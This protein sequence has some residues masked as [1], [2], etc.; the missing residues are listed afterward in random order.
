MNNDNIVL[1][2]MTN[3]PAFEF[4]GKQYSVC[5]PGGDVFS[6]WDSDG[7]THDFHGVDDLLDNWNI[8]GKPFGNI[9]E[10]IM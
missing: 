5:C 9:V 1:F 2:L 3:E 7:N 4:G 10:T 8:G 6:T